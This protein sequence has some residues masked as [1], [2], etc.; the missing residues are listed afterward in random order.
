MTFSGIFPQQPMATVM[1]QEEL[2]AWGSPKA[3]GRS[4]SKGEPPSIFFKLAMSNTQTFLTYVSQALNHT[5]TITVNPETKIVGDVRIG[6]YRNMRAPC[7]APADPIEMPFIPSTYVL[8]SREGFRVFLTLK[9]QAR[10]WRFG[11]CWQ[12]SCTGDWLLHP[13]GNNSR[14]PFISKSLARFSAKQGRVLDTWDA[15]HAETQLWY[16]KVLFLL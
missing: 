16:W 6:Q 9:T 12:L 15:E 5:A 11:R 10:P 7:N 3:K 13:Q 2:L 8:C 14:Q 4:Q 1:S